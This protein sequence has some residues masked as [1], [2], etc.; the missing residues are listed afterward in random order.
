VPEDGG[1]TLC[2]DCASE[3]VELLTAWQQHGQPPV[4]EESTIGDGYTAVAS[5]CSFCADGC[6]GDVLGVELYRRT[7]DEVPA[8]ANYTLCTDCRSVFGEFLQNVRRE[9]DS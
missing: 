4:S 6:G 3:V 8:Y 5:D 7:G 1:L 9:A 2:P